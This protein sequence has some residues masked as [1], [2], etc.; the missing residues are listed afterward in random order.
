[1]DW[2]M[3]A[4]WPNTTIGADPCNVGACTND[5]LKFAPER[6]LALCEEAVLPVACAV[7][8]AKIPG[9]SREAAIRCTCRQELR[10]AL[11]GTGLNPR[12]HTGPSVP[13][14]L[15]KVEK[16]VV[17]APASALSLGVE[18]VTDPLNLEAASVRV[19]RKA[20]IHV[21]RLRQMGVAWDAPMLEEYIPGEQ[22]CVSGVSRDGICRTFVP[23][24]QVWDDRQRVILHYET[25]SPAIRNSLQK[26]AQLIISALGLSWCGWNFEIRGNP[27]AWKLIDAHARLGEDDADYG[28]MMGAGMDPAIA[29]IEDLRRP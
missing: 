23:L 27:G 21:D 19:M 13:A 24:R 16:V 18:V 12:Y 22:Y 11:E 1:M 17:K 14:W 28:S 4:G 29:A 25:A 3:G 5:L 15:E 7:E 20:Y 8:I 9:L 2:A 6:I 26:V 10:L